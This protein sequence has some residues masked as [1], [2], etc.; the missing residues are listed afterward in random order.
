MELGP[1]IIGGVGGSGTRVFGESLLSAGIRTSHDINLASDALLCTLLFKRPS[2]L[3]DIEAGAPFERLWRMLEAGIHG[4][5]RLDKSDRQLL[6]TLVHEDRV[7]HLTK[8]LRK[9]ARCIKKEAADKS[10]HR[11]WFLKEPNLHIV[12][13]KALE[14]RPDLKFVMVVRHGVDMAFSKNQQQL[15][16]W[17][18]TFLDDS[19][20]RLGP[21]ASL[22]YWCVVHRRIA[23]LAK[24]DPERVKIF[25]FDQLCREP[26]HVLHRLFEFSS[27]EP[28]DSLMRV[29][30]EGVKT[31]SSIGRRYNEDLSIFAKED[32][33]F[34]DDFMATIEN[35]LS[36]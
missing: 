14:I 3:Q 29:A 13:P 11:R 36:P 7:H 17:G 20:L 8:W 34:V 32:M 24:Q 12:A 6:K 23:E 22:W 16:V 18:P 4:D 27:V 33:D 1:I 30:S 26:D 31:P 2:V 28:T 25:S 21:V 19:E 9:R 5:S 35:A 15:A 10:K